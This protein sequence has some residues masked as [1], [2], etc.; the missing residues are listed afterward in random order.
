[1][2]GTLSHS[3]VGFEQGSVLI[4]FGEDFFMWGRAALVLWH[5]HHREGDDG[6]SGAS[7]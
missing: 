5:G 6:S 2:T 4:R 7:H 3:V 1:V